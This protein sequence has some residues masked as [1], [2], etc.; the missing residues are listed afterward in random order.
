LAIFKSRLYGGK[1]AKICFFFFAQTKNNYSLA[2]EGL[3]HCCPEF[4]KEAPC[5]G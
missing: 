3:E 2:K 4:D 5:Q 1:N